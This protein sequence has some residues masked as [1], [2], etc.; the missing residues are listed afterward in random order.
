MQIYAKIPTIFKLKKKISLTLKPG[1]MGHSRYSE[2]RWLTHVS[3]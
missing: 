3:G 2:A 1:L